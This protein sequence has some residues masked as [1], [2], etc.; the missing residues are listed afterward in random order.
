MKL[1]LCGINAKFSHTNL[2][3]RYLY[4]KVNKINGLETHVKEFTINNS[5]ELILREIISGNYNIVALSAYI[6]NGDYIEMLCNNIKLISPE[7]IIIIGGPQVSFS[8]YP[9]FSYDYLISGEGEITLPLLIEDILEGDAP[10]EK[11]IDGVVVENLDTLPFPYDLSSK[12]LDNRILYYESSRGCPF[13]CSYC[14]SS[15]G[16]GVRIKSINR[17]KE[18]LSLF[19]DKKVNQVKFVDRTFNANNKFFQ[20][21]LIFLKETYN[22]HTNFHFEIS[23][24]LLK[25]SAIELIS[26]LPKGMVQFEI[27]VQSTNP[28]TLKAINRPS[29]NIRLFQ[30]VDKIHSYGNVHLHLDLIAGL[31]LEDYDSFRKSFN[32]VYSHKPHQLQLGFL[33]LL[34]GSDLMMDYKDYGIVSRDYAPFEVLYT[35]SLSFNDALRLKEV[36]D[37]VDHYYNSGRYGTMIK[38]LEGDFDNAFDFYQNLGS[39]YHRKEYHLSPVSQLGRY[40]ILYNFAKDMELQILGDL[41]E[42]CRYDMLCHNPPNKLPSF[43]SESKSFTRDSLLNL[44]KD[45]AFIEKHLPQYIN[46][47]PKAV[48]RNITAEKFSHPIITGGEDVTYIFDYNNRGVNGMVIP[49]RI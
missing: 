8:P 30:A 23:A 47:E 25:D 5:V 26:T 46:C 48:I 36:E 7:T 3:I 12:E 42:L 11:I 29:D 24:D 28:H 34:S 49:I 45:Q 39:Y 18:E 32:D 14:L 27:G 13:S 2:A 31:P 35:D 10:K 43:V 6:W 9:Q 4:H 1:L 40:E 41:E 37:M 20:E 15:A 22:G 17:V 38:G 44:L 16:K 19:I 33:K 21:V